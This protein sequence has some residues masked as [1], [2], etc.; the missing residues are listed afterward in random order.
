[1]LSP[2]EYYARRGFNYLQI[3]GGLLRF[4]PVLT[5]RGGDLGEL[6]PRVSPWA[7]FDFSLKGEGKPEGRW[8]GFVVSHPCRKNARQGWGTRPTVKQDP[9]WTLRRFS[10]AQI[11]QFGVFFAF[12]I[13][14]KSRFPRLVRRIVVLKGWLRASRFGNQPI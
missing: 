4:H 3:G 10:G 6:G 9:A 2:P 14:T 12:S 7:I 13:A 8:L 11:L 5:G 1:M